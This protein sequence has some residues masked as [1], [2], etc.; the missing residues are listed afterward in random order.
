MEASSWRASLH[1][2]MEAL[3]E[4]VYRH[5]LHCLLACLLGETLS[6]VHRGLAGMLMSATGDLAQE[7]CFDALSPLLRERAGDV[8]DAPMGSRAR[9]MCSPVG[10]EDLADSV[11]SCH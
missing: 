2:A 1:Q 3:G 9:D 8:K 10:G 11:E 6:M 4:T 7:V 5:A